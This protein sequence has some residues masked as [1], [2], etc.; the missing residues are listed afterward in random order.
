MR[1]LWSGEVAISAAKNWA[2]QVPGTL[3][4][5]SGHTLGTV[6]S[7]DEDVSELPKSKFQPRIGPPAV[8]LWGPLQR[9]VQTDGAMTQSLFTASATKI[10]L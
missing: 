7:D 8:R 9:T 1:I 4:A 2:G 3:R 6:V 5:H 10:V